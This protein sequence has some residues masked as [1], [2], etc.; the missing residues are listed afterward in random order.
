VADDLTNL[1]AGG[2]LVMGVTPSSY[3]AFVNADL[4]GNGALENNWQTDSALTFGDV[5]I[6][7]VRTGNTFTSYYKESQGASWTQMG[8]ARTINSAAVNSQVGLFVLSH[9][10]SQT[11]TA[12]FDNFRAVGER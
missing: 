3:G 4:D 12:V 10:G 2:Y 6:R 5:W 9:D 7:L 11:C 1:S 8:S